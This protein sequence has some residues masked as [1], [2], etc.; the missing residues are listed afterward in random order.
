MRALIFL[1]LW[2]LAGVEQVF[3]LTELKTNATASS[4]GNINTEFGKANANFSELSTAL[5]NKANTSCFASESAFATCFP[6]LSHM[7]W[8]LSDTAPAD[9][10]KL[11]FDTDQVPGY[12]VLKVHDGSAWKENGSYTLPTASA[13]TKGGIKVGDRLSI[14]GDGVL[15]ADVQ[16]TDISGKEDSLGNPSVN[17][18]VLSST[19]TGTRSWVEMTGGGTGIA[20]ATADGN[21]YASKDGGW[22]SLTGLYAPALGADDNYVT[23]AEKAKIAGIAEGAEV[24]VN[25]DWNSSSGDSQILNKPTIPTVSTA[26]YNTSTW[27]ASTSAP[28]QNALRDYLVNFDTDGDGDFTDEAWFPTGSSMVYPGAGIPNST[29]SAWGTSYTLDTDLSSVSASDDS[30]PSAKA[31]KAALDLKANSTN[32]SFVAAALSDLKYDPNTGIADDEYNLITNTG[33]VGDANDATVVPTLERAGAL[34]QAK[35]ANMITWPSAVSATEVG[36]LDGV[37]SAIQTQLNGK[38]ATD[39]THTGT[40][41]PYDTTILKDADI[42][43]TVQAYDANMITW[44]SAISATEVGYLDGLTDTILN[45][46]AGKQNADADL[47]DDAI[48]FVIDGGG[49]AITTGTKGFL[50]VPYNATINRATIVCDQSGSIVVDVWKDSYANY[51]PT[52]ADSI[53]ASAVPTVS[54]ATKVQDTTLTGWTTSLSAGDF[55]G[56]NVD[57]AS[58]VT[59]CTISLK[60]TK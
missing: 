44:P 42:G 9:L 48:E 47:D 32:I 39:H 18:Y 52:D 41:E 1:I 2:L 33:S 56:F 43:V 7:P 59:S 14:D 22:V 17:G 35:D 6:N 31:T 27:D 11:W 34:F 12:V 8:V 55:I 49:A 3:A 29:G 30:L 40:Y 20:H 16:T 15:S 51:P 13:E 36:Y 45:L 4:P 26:A 53:T 38:S 10:T 21:Y 28:D 24:N 60:V 37:T 58:T 19:T 50:E 25:A 46:L 57:S 54:T 23:D 5:G